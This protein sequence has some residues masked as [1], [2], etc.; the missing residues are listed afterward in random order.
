MNRPLSIR[1]FASSV[2]QRTQQLPNR[3]TQYYSIMKQEACP[4]AIHAYAA[5]V[6]A[7]NNEGVLSKGSCATEFAQVKECYQTVRR[8]HQQ[9]LSS[10]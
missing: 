8:N 1:T 2:Q 9:L 3:F 7:V 10:E 5:C 6:L 4:D